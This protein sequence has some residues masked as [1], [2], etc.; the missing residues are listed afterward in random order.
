MLAA[1]SPRTALHEPDALL[2]QAPTH[3][4]DQPFTVQPIVKRITVP[5]ALRCMALPVKLRNWVMLSVASTSK[6]VRLRRKVGF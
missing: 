6:A 4:P 2:C 1:R 3:G 5:M